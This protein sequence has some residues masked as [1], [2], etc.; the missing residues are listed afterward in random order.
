MDNIEE[1]QQKVRQHV[2]MLATPVN[3]DRLCEDGI[4]LK[5]SKRQFKVLDEK[6][7]PQHVG[8]RISKTLAENV[9]EFGKTE[10]SASKLLKRLTPK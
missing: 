6:R 10:K 4:L 1:M 7:L 3:F 2:E 5:V 8:L 9:V